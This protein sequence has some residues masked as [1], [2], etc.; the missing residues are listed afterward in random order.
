MDG[1]I[2]VYIVFGF[3][4]FCLLSF[5][6]T[7]WILWSR[8]KLTFCNFLGDTGKW[9]RKSFKEKDFS[10]DSK[11]KLQTFTYDGTPY[12]FDIKKVTHD[13][14]NRPIAHYYKGNPNQLIFDYS[15]M[16]KSITVNAKEITPKDFTILMMSKIFRDIFSDE[17]LMM[18]IYIIIGLIVIFGILIS[19]LVITHHPACK[20]DS[21]NETINIIAEGVR[22]GIKLK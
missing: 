3:F 6:I 4:A 22:K 20:L 11:H 5:S 17:E 8:R 10:N 15:Q 1:L 18:M 13:W 14:I 12:N 2:I 9:E 19:I 16:N 21:S 7:I